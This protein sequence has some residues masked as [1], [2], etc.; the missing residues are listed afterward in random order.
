MSRRGRL[1]KNITNRTQRKKDYWKKKHRSLK[2]QKNS[3]IEKK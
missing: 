1:V 2:E 3:Y